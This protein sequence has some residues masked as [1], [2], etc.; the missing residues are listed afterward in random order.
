MRQFTDFT[1]DIRQHAVSRTALVFFTHYP[2][3]T[4]DSTADSEPTVT[5]ILRRMCVQRAVA[6]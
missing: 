3:G 4:D 5:S 2:P 6:P 1:T